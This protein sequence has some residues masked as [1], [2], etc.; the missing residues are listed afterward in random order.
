MEDSSVCFYFL[1]LTTQT[2]EVSFPTFRNNEQREAEH[3][4]FLHLRSSL[5]PVMGKV[6]LTGLFCLLGLSINQTFWCY[7]GLQSIYKAR[8]LGRDTASMKE[9]R[10]KKTFTHLVGITVPTSWQHAIPNPATGTNY[11]ALA[12]PYIR[13]TFHING[14]HRHIQVKTTIFLLRSFQVLAILLLF[15]V[16]VRTAFKHK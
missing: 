6:D 8:L 3:F 16:N 7:P 12:L 5:H 9:Y 11:T 2:T 13:M 14:K 4:P 10:R 15:D 1:G